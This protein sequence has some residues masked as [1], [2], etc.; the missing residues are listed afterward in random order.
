MTKT[1]PDHLSRKEIKGPDQFQVAATQ[2]VDWMTHRRKQVII[3]SAV[4]VG[5]AVLIA[6]F[7]TVRASRQRE[8]GALLYRAIE[9]AGGE[10]SSVPLSGVPAPLFKTD[11]ER[12]RAVIEA[13]QKV[14][15]RHGGSRAAT[16][17]T[18]MMG[19]AHYRLGEWD[20]AL[21]A[22]RAFLGA[23]PSDDSM[24]FAALDG[25]ARSL[26]AKNQLDDAV[27]A[28]DEAAGQKSYADRAALEKARVLAKAG[29]ADEARKI[30]TAFPEQHKESPLRAEAA[31]QM[32]G[33]GG[34]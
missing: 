23:A 26:E 29:K 28:W 16:T 8:A 12:Q 22:Y 4:V 33:L 1:A 14:R 11:A 21:E 27:K 30:L 18:L 17:A 24:R 25:V 34:K 10:I 20:K 7:V 15:E 6:V 9:A 5:L 13:A 19:N 2:A 3:G 31:E 32:A